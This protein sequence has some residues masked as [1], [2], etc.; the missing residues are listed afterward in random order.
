MAAITEWS[1][2]VAW[3]DLHHVEQDLVISRALCAIYQDEFLK[4]RL[5]FRGGT[6]I[7]K[8]FIPPQKRYSEDIDLV[9]V[10]AEPIGAVLY[11]YYVAAS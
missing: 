5:A 2:S 4:E 9:Q 7:H 8:L 10:N 3:T 11:I 6:A 1:N